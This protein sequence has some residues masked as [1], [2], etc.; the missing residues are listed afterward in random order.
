MTFLRQWAPRSRGAEPATRRE[1]PAEGTTT[2]HDGT[3]ELQ[4]KGAPEGAS[5]KVAPGRP[6]LPNNPE[7]SQ[8]AEP[9]ASPDSPTRP[10][11]LHALPGSQ[12]PLPES[13]REKYSNSHRWQTHRW[14]DKLG[15]FPG[16]TSSHTALDPQ[17]EKS[18]GVGWRA[19]SRN[20]DT[21][22]A[23]ELARARLAA[24]AERS[25]AGRQAD[26]ARRAEAANS[27]H[28]PRP[29][30]GSET[31]GLPPSGGRAAKDG[32]GSRRGV[33]SVRSRGQV[34]PTMPDLASSPFDDHTPA[35]VEG[36]RGWLD[37]GMSESSS[38]CGNQ[39]RQDGLQVALRSRSASQATSESSVGS[40]ESTKI[41]PNGETSLA[42]DGLS[43]SA[44]PLPEF[45]KVDQFGFLKKNDGSPSM[46]VVRNVSQE[47]NRLKKWRRMVGAGGVDWKVYIQKNPKTVK[48]RIRKG[49]PDALRGLTWQLL[50]GGRSLLLANEGVYHQLMLYESSMEQ[51]E[52]EI[53]RDLNRTYPGHVYFQQRQGPGQRSLFNVLKAYSVYDK[54]VGYVQ[55]MGFIAGLLLLYMCEEDAFWTFVALLKG[56]VHPPMEGL[57]TDGFPLLQQYFYQFE[58]IIKQ[59]CPQ[60]GAHFEKENVMPI[61]FCSHWFNTVF[62]YSLPFEHL[63]RLWDVFMFEGWKIV[64][65]V[66]LLLLKS[67]EDQLLSKSFEG[68][69]AIL[70]SNSKQLTAEQFPILGRS[71]DTFIKACLSIKVSKYLERC[72]ADYLKQQQ[73]KQQEQQ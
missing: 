59:E 42:S 55:G 44:T 31:A 36:W 30:V 24:A 69:M 52:L 20:G 14:R 39:H 23:S 35:E 4:P 7:T 16:A 73:N 8:V 70:N 3:G 63:L 38:T 27:H 41:S 25:A 13:L 28:C 71:P 49:I 62:A 11:S 51:I 34:P 33:A 64:F 29:G 57:Y 67:A 10:G 60:I 53:V 12:F 72:K 26:R 22:P 46:P 21:R 48:N 15:Q 19:G 5:L 6:P 47:C 43:S 50:S 32:E 1:A 68:M 18:R 56:Q 40:E 9:A 61:M 54:K 58:Y 65:R 66:G 2:R 45:E 17:K 37:S